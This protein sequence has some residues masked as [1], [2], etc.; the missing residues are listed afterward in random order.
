MFEGMKVKMDQ[1]ERT[2]KLRKALLF[3]N[4]AV[5]I[6]NKLAE[7]ASVVEDGL[8]TKVLLQIHM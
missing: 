8:S 7:E 3:A 6:T 5:E 4:D 1:H 2:D